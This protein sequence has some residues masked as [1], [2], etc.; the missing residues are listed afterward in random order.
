MDG[1]KFTSVVLASLHVCLPAGTSLEQW[2][3]IEQILQHCFQAYG[4]SH[5]TIS[6]ELPRSEPQHLNDLLAPT[7]GCNRLSSSQ[8][9]FGC[10]VSELKKRKLVGGV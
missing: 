6:P 3:E 10:A 7:G 5:V 4:I 9:E 1:Q 8:D 2:E